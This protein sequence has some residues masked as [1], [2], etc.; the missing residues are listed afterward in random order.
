MFNKKIRVTMK[1]LVNPKEI[2]ML[3]NF[4]ASDADS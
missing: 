3:I 1:R 4:L 2:T